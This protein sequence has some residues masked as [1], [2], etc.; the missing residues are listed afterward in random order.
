MM[1]MNCHL[2]VIRFPG[3]FDQNI[4]GGEG[5][6]ENVCMTDGSRGETIV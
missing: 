4:I 1:R 6:E 5:K 2:A 3:K